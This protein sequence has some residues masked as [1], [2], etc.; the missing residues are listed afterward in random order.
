[1]SPNQIQLLEFEGP[2]FFWDDQNEPKWREWTRRNSQILSDH[3]E[4]L[5]AESFFRSSGVGRYRLKGIRRAPHSFGGFFSSER[6]LLD[7]R[8]VREHPV[9]MLRP[10]SRKRAVGMPAAT[11]LV[12]QPLSMG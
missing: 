11:T 4:T 9:L 10:A 2:S 3:A 12:S 6:Y 7:L 1:M 5:V 8:M